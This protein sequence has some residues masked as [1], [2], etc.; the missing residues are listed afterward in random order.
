MFE[1]H[2]GSGQLIEDRRFVRL[3]AVTAQTLIPQVVGHDE[4]DVGLLRD[5]LRSIQTPTHCQKRR[6][7]A[8]CFDE[9]TS[10]DS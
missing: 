9:L 1:L 10:I 5:S 7:Q 6:T 2:T 4:N 8:C 3:A